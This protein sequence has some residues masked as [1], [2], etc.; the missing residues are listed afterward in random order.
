MSSRG[1]CFSV[2]AVIGA[3]ALV[4]ATSK[5]ATAQQASPTPSPT[6]ISESQGA[7]GNAPSSGQLN[8][9]EVTGVL[10]PTEA[11]QQE[12]SST[13]GAAHVL[14]TAKLFDTQ[15]NSLT[16][17][18]QLQ[19]TPGVWA[20]SSGGNQG[21]RLSIRGSSLINTNF[22]KYGVGFYFNGLWFPG[23]AESGAPPYLFEGLATR[24][25]EVLPGE[26][27]F[28]LQTLDLGGAINFVD[29]TGYDAAPLE[30]RFDVGSREYFKGQVSSGLVLGPAD[31]YI[32]ITASSDHGFQDHSASMDLKVIGN[33]GYQ[34]NPN[35]QN[36]FYYRYGYSYFQYGGLLTNQQIAQNPEQAQLSIKQQNRTLWAPGTVW[37]GDKLTIQIDS[38][39]SFEAGLMYDYAYMHMNGANIP[40]AFDGDWTEQ[41]VSPS[42]IYKRSDELFGHQNIFTAAFRGDLVFNSEAHYFDYSSGTSP[43][44]GQIYTRHNNSGTSEDV[45]S[46][47]DNIEILPKLWLK[48][49]V[50]GVFTRMVN[51][52]GPTYEQGV[53][54]RLPVDN[55]NA[56]QAHFDGEWVAGLRY[57]LTPETQLFA[58]VSRSVESTTGESL[59]NDSYTGENVINNQTA[60]TWEV[61]TRFKFWVF[62]G[63]LDYYY[64]AVHNEIL[65]VAT[66]IVPAL[67]TNTSN[68]SPTTHQGVELKLDT[69]L[70]QSNNSRLLFTQ[71]YTWSD[72]YFNNDP[73]WGHNHLPAFPEHFYQG[74]IRF[75]HASGVYVGFN[76]QVTSGIWE[77]FANTSQSP[78]YI[79]FG[80]KIGY[81]PP[82]KPWEI[83]LDFTN[84][85]DRHYAVYIQ[86]T[87]DLNSPSLKGTG[88]AAPGDG[89]GIY[90]GFSYKLF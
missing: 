26:N 32:S 85:T 53:G 52:D 30:V 28:D 12:L 23:I 50:A 80:A 9:V 60:T 1:R 41:N 21:F 7:S 19:Y 86:Q 29:Y 14:D 36:R 15:T 3:S 66:E 73:A 62:D 46:T 24:Y 84:L 88:V 17:A 71:A 25:T 65:T 54:T 51:Y 49:G 75:E 82:K 42:L 37:L 31:Y 79:I 40:F 27:A 68:A 2:V 90:G 35:I 58:N 11:A 57:D 74:E 64:S 47:S 56:V 83:H 34:I 16:A 72:F 61:G 81:A 4:L 6:P 63:S 70:W 87:A 69:T 77:D 13:P 8:Q 55:S 10:S 5:P 43:T 33:I 89:F 45:L 20:Q 59:G 48:L 39:S 44:Y 78:G 18:Q 22:Y 38:S 76:A 67:I